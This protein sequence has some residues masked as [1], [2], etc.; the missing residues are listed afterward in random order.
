M[1]QA[2]TEAVVEEITGDMLH[3]TV[4]IFVVRLQRVYKVEVSQIEHVFT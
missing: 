1:F 3:N 4:D 2:K